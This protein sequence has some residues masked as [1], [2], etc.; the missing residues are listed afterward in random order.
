MSNLA[1]SSITRD[2]DAESKPRREAAENA[3]TTYVT[4]L[5]HNTSSDEL[6]EVLKQD[7]LL[8]AQL[9]KTIAGAAL[10]AKRRIWD[11]PPV[12]ATATPQATREPAPKADDMNP[13]FTTLG[14]RP[15]K[16]LK[17]IV[18]SVGDWFDKQG[19]FHV[20]HAEHTRRLDDM[21]AHT[22][23]VMDFVRNAEFILAVTTS[24]EENME[25]QTAVYDTQDHLL[26]ILDELVREAFTLRAKH[27]E[28]HFVYKCL[29]EGTS[30]HQDNQDRQKRLTVAR[31]LANE[32]EAEHKRKAAGISCSNATGLRNALHALVHALNIVPIPDPLTTTPP[33][34]TPLTEAGVDPF[35]AST[36]TNTGTYPATALSYPN[37]LEGSHR[38]TPC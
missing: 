8:C 7:N 28:G 35:V 37:P 23:A 19:K 11:N 3:K 34:S 29:I 26:S 27:E 33:H 21:L 17:E 12:P 32:K 5:P 22:W 16:D 25:F 38:G 18:R 30:F 4:T 20:S 9:A 14:K 13:G 36:A 15:R 10:L 6:K 24:A 1:E 2:L 31:K